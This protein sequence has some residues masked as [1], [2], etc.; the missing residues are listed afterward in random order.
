MPPAND[1][2]E[3]LVDSLTDERDELKEKVTTLEAELKELRL[4][5]ITAHGESQAANERTQSV[6]KQAAKTELQLREQ[7][8]AA[9]SLKKP[10]DLFEGKKVVWRGTVKELDEAFRKHF[11]Q[12]GELTVVLG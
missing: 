10:V 5:L 9:N 3:S 4:E 2:L 6:E 8:K 11:I 7:L 12:E 1:D